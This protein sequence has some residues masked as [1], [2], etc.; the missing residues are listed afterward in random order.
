MY[1]IHIVKSHHLPLLPVSCNQGECTGVRPGAWKYLNGFYAKDENIR[2]R[3][4]QIIT[5]F[6]LLI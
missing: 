2:G 6:R 4:L 1:S 3:G 5:L